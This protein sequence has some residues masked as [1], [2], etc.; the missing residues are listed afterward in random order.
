MMRK[1]RLDLDTLVV[2]SFTP[3]PAGDAR[4]GTIQAHDA[5]PTPVVR[6]LPLSNC[7]VSACA[8]CGIYC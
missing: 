5:E 8:T 3:T 2:E 6:T 7:V 1:L 4:P